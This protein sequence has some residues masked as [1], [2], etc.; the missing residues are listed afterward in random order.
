M[1]A[2]K[3]IH[4]HRSHGRKTL[5]WQIDPT[6]YKTLVSEFMLQQTQV[7]TVI[8]YFSQFIKRFP[9]IRTLARARE[10]SILAQWSGL[11]YYRRAK[12]LHLSAKYIYKKFNGSIPTDIEDLVLLPGIGMSTAGAIRSLAFNLPGTIMDGNVIRVLTRFLGLNFD[13]S[14]ASNIKILKGKGD[15][16]L[17]KRNFKE[18]S[19]GIM[20]L[21]ALICKKNAPLCM[22]CPISKNCHAYSYQLQGMLPLKKK[23][24]Q[25]P[26]K[27]QCALIV[28]DKGS[29]GILLE[30]RV[31]DELWPDLFVIPIF[32][33][34]HEMIKWVK[35][36]N[37]NEKNN[38]QLFKTSKLTF[39][40]FKLE[41]IT[42]LLELEI[43]KTKIRGGKQVYASPNNIN[44]LGVPQF[45][46]KLIVELHDE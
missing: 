42:Y 10:N 41:L 44:K 30:K 16:L 5:P 29:K 1:F 26:I 35:K 32:K 2:K 12:N 4:W 38:Y 11:G 8:P 25:I 39:S 27:K 36:N 17:P 34:K 20:D 22:Q 43:N 18:Y 21:G 13:I 40:H 45:I 15:Q 33:N 37:F 6:P 7:E 19:Q 24:K 9:N 14:K 3:I 28:K 46:K 23:K 31:N